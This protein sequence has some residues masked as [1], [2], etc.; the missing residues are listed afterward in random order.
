MVWFNK[1]QEP[2]KEQKSTC[3]S[4]SIHMFT[5]TEEHM[6]YRFIY[7]SILF[8]GKQAFYLKYKLDHS[9]TDMLYR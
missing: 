5:N 2:T 4:Y 9:G 7:M 6:P 8:L 3:I 1:Q